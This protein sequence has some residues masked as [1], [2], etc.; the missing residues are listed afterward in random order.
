MFSRFLLTAS[1]F[2][3]ATTAT[4]RADLVWT[5]T[6]GNVIETSRR[7][8]T[9]ARTL[10]DLVAVTGNSNPEPRGITTDGA[11][12]LYWTDLGQ[13]GTGV[14]AGIY[15]ANFD[16]SGAV[17]LIDPVAALGGAV[18]DYSPEGILIAAD[19]IYW[20]DFGKSAVYFADLDGS[21]VALFASGVTNP[22]GIAAAG[23]RIFWNG[24]TARKIFSADEDGGNPAEFFDYATALPAVTNP[25]DL[26]SDGVNL[27]LTDPD[28]GSQDLFVINIGTKTPFTIIED[29]NALG[30]VFADGVLYFTDEANNRLY[31]VGDNGL[32]LAELL[33]APSGDARGITLIAPQ[34]LPPVASVKATPAKIQEDSKKPLTFTIT[35]SSPATSNFTIPYTIGGK[36]KV[37]KD[38]TPRGTS[39][40]VVIPQGQTSATVTLKMKNDRKR[41]SKK[42][43]TLS[44]GAGLPY[45]VGPPATATLLDDDK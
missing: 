6:E 15:R 44:L 4:L 43:I 32:E 31:K 11:T 25:W 16:G 39:G 30:A 20:T 2:L 18:G 24:Q 45:R 40:T 3:A 38:F 27:Y 5:S 22:R 7:D 12:Y 29:V 1:L 36:A 14:G 26:H 34:P 33:A 10:V 8:G 9:N 28:L 41:E 37:G 21:N 42:T 13:N 23:G 19:K 35:L 17:R